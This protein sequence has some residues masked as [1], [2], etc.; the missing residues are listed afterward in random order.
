[1]TSF[2]YKSEFF[3]HETLTKIQGEPDY[4]SLTII[5]KEMQA[6]AQ[7]V[8]TTLGGGMVPMDFWD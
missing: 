6:N 8:P 3:L 4:A 1:M 2:N 5:K 7:A